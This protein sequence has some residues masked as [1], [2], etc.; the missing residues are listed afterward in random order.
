MR[1]LALI[2]LAVL[3]ILFMVA[4]SVASSHGAS[5][6]RSSV[7]D[8]LGLTRYTLQRLR[9]TRGTSAASFSLELLGRRVTLRLEPKSLRSSDFRLLMQQADGTLAES[10]APAPLTYRGTVAEM[11]GAVVGAT[12]RDGLLS[13][14]IALEDGRLFYVQ[15]AD[16]ASSEAGAL[17]AVYSADS[18]VAE[19]SCAANEPAVSVA[20]APR[21]GAAILAGPQVTELAIDA[22]YEL[23]TRNGSSVAQTVSDVETVMNAV[24]VIYERDGNLTHRLVTV[25]VRSTTPDPYVATDAGLALDELRNQWNTQHT[26]IHRDLVHLMTGRDLDGSTIGIAAV[27]VVCNVSRAYGLSQTRFSTTLSRRAALTAHEIGHNWNASHCDGAAEC[28]IMCSSIG[29]CNGLGLPNFEPQG[30]DAIKSYAASRSCLETPVMAVGATSGGSGVRLAPAQPS[31]FTRQTSLAF[32]LEAAGPVR[33][34]I[35]DVAGQRVALLASGVEGAGWHRRTWNGLDERGG[36]VHA[37][38][39]YARLETPAGARTQELILVK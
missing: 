34:A 39:F 21:S 37:G 9:G 32:F 4:L 17:H 7:A 20:P 8:R 13:A 23:F 31:P 19:G 22:D 6:P 25:V 11:P 24:N 27:G 5:L 29:G 1:R 10:P 18:V 2:G 35:Y 12:I 15:P 33:L 26:G 14:V 16:E 36:R 38:V 30:I 28:H 3:A